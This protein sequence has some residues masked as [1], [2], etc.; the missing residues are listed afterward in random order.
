MKEI[1]TPGRTSGGPDHHTE[2]PGF[3]QG[4]WHDLVQETRFQKGHGTMDSTGRLVRDSTAATEESGR[5]ESRRATAK[6]DDARESGVE[7]SGKRRACD[8]EI[9]THENLFAISPSFWVENDSDGIQAKVK[10]K[11]RSQE[12]PNLTLAEP[13]NM[14]TNEPAG[15]AEGHPA[16]GEERQDIKTET[17]AL[18]GAEGIDNAADETG[19]LNADFAGVLQEAAGASETSEEEVWGVIDSGATRGFTLVSAAE[20]MTR[21]MNIR[22]KGQADSGFVINTAERSTYIFANGEAAKT[23]S[24]LNWTKH[25]G[26]EVIPM[27]LAVLET[28]QPTT[29]LPLVGL[30]FLRK[31]KAVIDVEA[32]TMMLRGVEGNPT[33]RLKKAKNGHLLMPLIGDGSQS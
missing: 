15:E 28:E 30:D 17:A 25:V 13:T 33:I 24:T 2:G 9:E 32:A 12:G 20:K 10:D 14:N 7:M 21:L 26:T 5:Q 18:T 29:Q 6:L 16:T 23:S 22:Y 31:V 4:T 27:T 3:I 11:H 8:E 19:G 1:T